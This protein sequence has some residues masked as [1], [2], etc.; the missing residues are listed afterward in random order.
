MTLQHKN[1]G[2]V[3]I[4]LY[5]ACGALLCLGVATF[6]LFVSGVLYG[7]DTAM[8]VAIVGGIVLVIGLTAAVSLYGLIQRRPWGR[9]ATMW[10]NGVGILIGVLP[11]LPI[12]PSMGMSSSA[13]VAQVI[14]IT[15][16]VMCIQY[17]ARDEVRQK[18]SA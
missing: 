14:A 4:S 15:L 18:F 16:S 6:L 8:P 17:L 1:M 13:K 5:T 12:L 3:L 10:L 11:F 9:S 2:L 7:Q